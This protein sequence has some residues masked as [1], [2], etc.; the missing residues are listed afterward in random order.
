MW[1]RDTCLVTKLLTYN[2]QSLWEC[3]RHC[4]HTLKDF[5]VGGCADKQISQSCWLGGCYCSWHQWYGHCWHQWYGHCWYQWYMDTVATCGMNTVA[6][7]G[8]NTV[9]ISGTWSWWKQKTQ[10]SLKLPQIC[11]IHWWVLLTLMQSDLL[12]QSESLV[13]QWETSLTLKLQ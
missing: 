4:W 2:N 12:N 10:P 11:Y 8:L 3:F 13:S 5:T 1:C 9:A 7:Y 6:M